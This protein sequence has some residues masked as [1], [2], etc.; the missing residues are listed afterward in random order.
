MLGESHP[1]L[2]YETDTLFMM[3]ELAEESSIKSSASFLRRSLT[4]INSPLV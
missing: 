3:P 1:F 4:Q 2:R